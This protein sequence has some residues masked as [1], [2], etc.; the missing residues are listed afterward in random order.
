M[1]KNYL[2][3][4]LLLLTN[5]LAVGQKVT[6]TPTTVN[7]AN[8]STG[9]I[10]LGSVNSS[11]VT[12][13]VKVALKTAPSD[14]NPGS[15][16]IY[17]QKSA[18]SPAITPTGGN[19]GGLLFL[20]S[21]T[22]ERSF[23]ISL[24]FSNFDPSGGIIYA[25]YKTYS[26]TIYKSDPISV[27]RQSSSTGG[28]GIPADAP[29]PANIANT[30]CCN[31]TVRLGDKPAPIV[32]SQYAN[33][34]ENY[35]YGINSSFSINSSLQFDIDHINK[36]LNFDYTTE[37]K[38]I[39]ITRSLGYN[40]ST[41]LPNK[42]NTVTI[43]V[44]PTPI[45]NN[46]IYTNEPVN[47]NGFIELSNVKKLNI[48]GS[49]STT[50]NLKILENPF[51]TPQ[52]RD[53]GA[54]VESYKWEY[55]KTNTNLSGFR[56]WNT[57]INE[58]SSEL[59]F[60]NPSEKSN[61]EDTYY[62]I[63][64]IAIY[65]NITNASEPIKVLI[66]GLRNNNTICCDQTLKITSLTEFDSP[67]T[68]IGS[69]P[70]IQDSNITGTNLQITSISYQWQSQSIGRS[71]ASWLDI[72]GAVSKDYLPNSI[73]VVENSGGRRGQASFSLESNYNYR[74]I[75]KINYTV[76]DNKWINGSLSSYS[77]EVS[78]TGS[79]NPESTKIYPNPT[80]SILNIEDNTLDISQAKI[81]IINI[82]GMVVNSNNFSIINPNLISINVS[83][84]I[85]GT[86][87][88]KIEYNGI[89]IAQKT[90]IK[91]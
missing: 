3:L 29:N 35:G 26:G 15:I 51:Y 20:G 74:R 47:S 70:I 71:T 65:K 40:S 11:T 48:Y 56:T 57:L 54:N 34:Y 16:D 87:I 78:L 19:G 69:T 73:K 90:F 67:Q 24:E 50:V 31:Q 49:R 83:N 85:T 25:E 44:V 64:R 81:S 27:I 6:L 61:S 41:N 58:N 36:T 82:M 10:N 38:N 53:P 17:Y 22:A 72:S 55:T 4:I 52:P 68:I 9:P 91:N 7:G 13:S 77:N 86:Y 32:G 23:N 30:L 2:Y 63:R 8:V 5:L 18:S 1:K 28:G 45:L 79:S 88:I 37:L 14:S 46:T 89:N 84:L 62:L 60:E 39:T 76:F 66:R 80:T 75:T 43:T 59:N 33:P 42:S 12:L 21:T